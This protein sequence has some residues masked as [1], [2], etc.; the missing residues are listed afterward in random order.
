MS[1]REE[2]ILTVVQQ[3]HNFTNVGLDTSKKKVFH[4]PILL[5]YL[6]PFVYF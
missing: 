1:I 5:F 2:S 4:P 3:L 6:V